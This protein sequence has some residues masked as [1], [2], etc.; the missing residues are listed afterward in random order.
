[1]NRVRRL[2]RCAAASCAWKGQRA[3]DRATASPCPRCGAS[4]WATSAP[5]GAAPKP[6]SER[7]VRVTVR[8]LESTVRVLGSE[9]AKLATLLDS[10]AVDLATVRGA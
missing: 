4:V 9:P 5:P 3:H 2:V 1:M 7:R 6:P 8:V 10:L